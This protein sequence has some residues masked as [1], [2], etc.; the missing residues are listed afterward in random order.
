MRE[1]VSLTVTTLLLLVALI[2]VACA[3]LV[4]T[5]VEASPAGVWVVVP[6]AGTDGSGRGLAR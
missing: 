5:R 2:G 4:P 6:D 1:R 3:Y